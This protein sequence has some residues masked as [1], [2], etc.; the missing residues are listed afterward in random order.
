[1]ASE[2]KPPSSSSAAAAMNTSAAAPT[3]GWL[4]PLASFAL[5][6]LLRNALGF[7]M[8]FSGWLLA[9]AL[10]KGLEGL[11]LR[12]MPTKPCM[13]PIVRNAIVFTANGLMV[14]M[15]VPAVLAY[16]EL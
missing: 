5:R 7:G 4:V 10:S 13:A 8:L 9:G 15:G 12:S 3:T 14:S 11:V 2:F 16:L 6:L 1:M